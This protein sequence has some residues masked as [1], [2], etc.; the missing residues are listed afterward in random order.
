MTD[1]RVLLQPRPT[2]EE[3][4]SISS[5]WNR[6]HLHELNSSHERSIHNNMIFI[7]SSKAR[8]IVVE[9]VEDTSEQ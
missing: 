2:A 4:L 1:G 7:S 5:W 3:I 9:G 8:A 6:P